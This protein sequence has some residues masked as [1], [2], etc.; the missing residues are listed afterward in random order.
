MSENKSDSQKAVGRDVTIDMLIEAIAQ[1]LQTA[2]ATN[3]LYV[4]NLTGAK[5]AGDAGSWDLPGGSWM[6]IQLPPR[7]DEPSVKALVARKR[8]KTVQPTQPAPAAA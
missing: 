1:R 5:L 8:R 4:R 2:D 6:M 7:G 3:V